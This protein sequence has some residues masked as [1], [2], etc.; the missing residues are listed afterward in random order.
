ME[1]Q[2][3][4]ISTKDLSVVTNGFIRLKTTDV[5]IPSG[6]TIITGASGS[7][8][9]TLLKTLCGITK[10]TTGSI[11]HWSQNQ[12]PAF[13]KEAAGKPNLVANIL[14]WLQL[15]SS[16]NRQDAAYRSSKTGYIPQLPHIPE[17]LTGIQYLS[18]PQTVRG[19]KLD[20]EYVDDLID[21][22]GIQ[23]VVGKTA[24]RM[25]GGELQRVTIAFA[26]E[27]KPAIVFADEPTAALDSANTVNAM[28][29]LRRS[30]DNEDLS[31]VCV[32]HNDIAR[33][34]ADTEIRMKDGE[35]TDVL[36]LSAKPLS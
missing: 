2:K 24:L 33:S 13:H 25:S 29:I 18:L 3:R 32:T 17:S 14:G 6:L 11:T 28:G 5:E 26:L 31:V 15:E 21:G 19:N 12:E 34:F 9:S 20:P 23:K 27:H 35:I 16:K 36:E 22:L 8:K 4:I 10:P 30:V 1:V 7:G